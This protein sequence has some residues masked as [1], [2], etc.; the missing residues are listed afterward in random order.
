MAETSGFFRSVS[1]DRKYTT[2][3]LAKW[4]SS[5][6][7]SG[8]YNGE[9]ALSP[10]GGM[11]VSLPAGKAWIKGYY[12]RNDAP[13]TLPIA[14]ADGVLHRKDT[15][16]LRWNVNERS[17]TA[18]VLQGSFASNP[19]APEIVRDL[20]LYD[21][22]LAEISIPAGTT[23][24]T[25][26]LITDTRLDK[27]VCGIVTG[28][29]NQVDTT[30]FYNQIAADLAQFKSI[31][32]T[33]FEAWFD[34][35]K[36]IL[37]EDEAGNLLTLINE[38][39]ANTDAH[40]I[41]YTH[42][43]TGTV[44]NFVGQGENGKAYITADFIVGDTF[45]VNGQSVIVK[46]QNGEQPT[47]DFF[48]E[49]CWVQFI[50]DDSNKQLN[51]SAGGSKQ[52]PTT[53]AGKLTISLSV[54]DGGDLGTTRVRI[55]NESLGM[56]LIYT[57]DALGKVTVEL[58]GNKTYDITL[59][60]VPAP[61]YGE[62][63][64]KNIAFDSDNSISLQ[65]KGQ[66]DIIGFRYLYAAS[67]LPP[68][69]S[70]EYIE[71]SV[72]W[73]PMSMSSEGGFTLDPGSFLNSWLVKDIRPCAIKAG[74]VQYYYKRTGFMMFDY[75]L[76]ENG[77]PAKTDGTDG[78]VMIEFPRVYMQLKNV[79]ESGKT[80]QEV[81]FS[82]TKLDS[83]WVDW[84]WT[85]RLG[86]SY[87]T[88]YISRYKANAFSGMNPRLVSVSKTWAYS[89]TL[90]VFRSYLNETT[91]NDGY[92]V[93]DLA[94]HTFLQLLFIMTFKTFDI[95]GTFGYGEKVSSTITS[96]YVGGTTDDKPLC[97]GLP[98]TFTPVSFFGLENM[99]GYQ[100]SISSSYFIEGV[101][102]YKQDSTYMFESYDRRPPYTLTSGIYSVVVGVSPN[103][104]GINQLGFSQD[105]VG[106]GVPS[107]TPS[108]GSSRIRNASYIG[109]IGSG[110]IKR[111]AR[112]D[113][114][115]YTSGLFSSEL[116][117]PI[118]SGS[119]TAFLTYKPVS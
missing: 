85:N 36:D 100:G 115:G 76:Q 117:Y 3:W 86:R 80:Y 113:S 13:I 116:N 118:S 103:S 9:L 18:Q 91:L 62:A 46:L 109:P 119:G 114:A 41:T 17:I 88:M 14:N 73:N 24:I 55:K 65:L 108:S 50:Y 26:A 64:T 112:G 15:V 104:G 78:N 56:N 38:H 7:G 105:G 84:A 20:E 33:D 19:I 47:E 82:K 75:G 61:Y 31:Q 11:S 89:S 1:G 98:G 110:Y 21:L 35:V 51:F 25:P 101:L 39:K 42:T 74:V 94:D 70:V 22:K 92:C 96:S 6:I 27:A 48:K 2:D 87:E 29:V 53:Y 28:V 10:G 43:K 12:Y 34:S 66:P 99:F 23:A 81:R 93:M 37:G 106:V 102:S 52:I 77:L 67:T 4:I 107:V 5:F 32:Q 44:H 8:V 95:A 68:T 71:G 97:Y 111:G 63:T 69:L 49:N 40:I 57:P 16:V 45:T 83:S 72:D 60:D 79:V 59:V 30:T 54:Y 90:A 58:Q